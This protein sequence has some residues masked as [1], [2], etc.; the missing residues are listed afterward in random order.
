ML[1]S[2]DEKVTKW[3]CSKCKGDEYEDGDKYRKTRNCDAEDSLNIAWSWMPSLRRCPWSQVTDEAWQIVQW[4]AEYKEFGCLPWGGG[5]LMGQPNFVLEGFILCSEI[6][7][8]VRVEAGKE[9]QRQ[10]Q[11]KEK[12]ASRSSSKTR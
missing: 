2:G 4:W 8:K 9:Q 6:K 5:D 7:N 11:R 12:S 3:G 10:W 1:L